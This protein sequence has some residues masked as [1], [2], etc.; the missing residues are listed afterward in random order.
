MSERVG[1]IEDGF[2]L[3]RT[4]RDWFFEPRCA[5]DRWLYGFLSPRMGISRVTGAQ[6]MDVKCEFG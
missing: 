3:D 4:V 5:G 6:S 1:K 2:N